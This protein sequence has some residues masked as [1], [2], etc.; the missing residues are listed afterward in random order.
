[1]TFKKPKGTLTNQNQAPGVQWKCPNLKRP[2]EGPKSTLTNQNQ[3]PRVQWKCPNLKRPNEGPKKTLTNQN[4]HFLV[5]VLCI[6]VDLIV[7]FSEFQR[8]KVFQRVCSRDNEEVWDY[9]NPREASSRSRI[10]LISLVYLCM[11]LFN[12]VTP[13][14]QTK[15]DTEL[16]FGTHTPMPWTLSKNVFFVLFFGKNL[17]DGRQPR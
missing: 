2:N 4:H 9:Q 11:Y 8:R 13:P 10:F 15:N 16:K 5:M 17:H 6:F 7:L 12:C 3:A 14:G 1:M